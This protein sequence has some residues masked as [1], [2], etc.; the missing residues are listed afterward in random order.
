M[1]TIRSGCLQSGLDVYNVWSQVWMFTV[2]SVCLQCLQS[3]LDVY[4]QV[5]MLTIRSGCLQSG[6]DVYNQVWMFIIRSVN[7]GSTVVACVRLSV[8][9]V[10]GRQVATESLR[11]SAGKPI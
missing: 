6:L 10:H 11:A 4:N 2:R 3:G 8:C 1:L 5:W 9:A 7:R